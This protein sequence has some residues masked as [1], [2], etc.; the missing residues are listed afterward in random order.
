[1]FIRKNW[2][3]LSVFLIAI[4]G[5]GLYYLQTRPP[6][7]PIKIYKA[8]EV[9][10]KPKPPPGETAESG[11]WHG[12]EWHAGSHDAHAPAGGS[13]Q[14]PPQL[15]EHTPVVPPTPP[16]TA[17]LDLKALEGPMMERYKRFQEIAETLPKDADITRRDVIVASGLVPSQEELRAMSDDELSSLRKASLEK[18]AEIYP[19]LDRRRERVINGANEPHAYIEAL[20]Y[21]HAFRGTPAELA[22]A[23][24]DRR[25]NTSFERL[26]PDQRFL[27]IHPQVAERLQKLLDERYERKQEEQNR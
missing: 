10:T 8:V 11:H 20:R 7:S 13:E 26:P 22:S 23:E 3:P 14:P 12:D 19:E 5:V 2:L 15:A 1:M 24:L 27:T 16:E 21:E 17:T 4:V 25:Y 9:E 6:K 18:A